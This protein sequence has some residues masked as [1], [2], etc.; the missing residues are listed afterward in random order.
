[1][2]NTGKPNLYTSDNSG[3]EVMIFGDGFCA[4]TLAA[5][6]SDYGIR[7][8][9]VT[10][11]PEAALMV[12]NNHINCLNSCELVECSGFAKDFKLVLKQKDALIAKRV[13]AIVVAE[14][15]VRLSNF[16]DYGLESHQRIIS[17][18]A[19]EDRIDQGSASRLFQKNDRILFLCGWQND[20]HPVVS[21]RML[22]ACLKVQAGF[23]VNTC[24]M[25]GNLKVSPKGCESIYQQAKRAGTVF[26][27]FTQSFPV[28]KKSQN[29]AFEIEYLDELTRS[30][31]QLRAD[32]IVVDENIKPGNELVN[33]SNILKIEIDGLGFAQSDNVHRL[34]NATNRRGIYVAGGSRGILSADEQRSDADQVAVKLLEF[35]E[36]TE[37]DMECP[38]EINRGRC[39]RCLTCHRSCPH[40]A[41]DIGHRIT[42][43]PQACWRCGICYASCPARAIDVSG[44]TISSD[45]N[46]SVKKSSIAQEEIPDTF[47][48]TVFG[49]ARSAGQAFNL[50]RLAGRQLPKEIQFVEVPC[51]GAISERHLL[52]AFEAGSDGV[53]L[54][55]CHTGN[56]RSE[57][58]NHLAR[59]RADSA[60]KVLEMAGIESERF[61]ITSI[62]ANMGNEFY[63]MIKTFSNRVSGIKGK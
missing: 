24:F 6:L 35:L 15:Y 48:V 44:L 4:R 30:I 21:Q 61:E 22:S 33:L 29:D 62:A 9:I 63:F 43:V 42:V 32:W 12:E 2:N 26:Y 31:S 55:T 1:M 60:R 3:F 10:N 28:I 17:I 37:S 5:N 46:K 58:G 40:Q 36:N 25:T 23:D 47:R 38:V 18:S 20:S 51:G 45:L 54:C 34:N 27:K 11:K 39:A 41:I 7:S 14:D 59:K 52:A 16:L 50:I 13:P 53:M 8:S 19:L 57:Q 49:C 56:C